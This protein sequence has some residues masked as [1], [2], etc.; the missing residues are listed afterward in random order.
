MGVLKSLDFLWYTY[1]VNVKFKNM[2]MFSHMI[3][4]IRVCLSI[5]DFISHWSV[6]RQLIINAVFFLTCTYQ[7]SHQFPLK[8]IFCL[9]HI[10]SAIYI[11][12]RVAHF[13]C[14]FG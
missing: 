7:N 5:K 2:S 6:S 11:K 4:I 8:N 13:E 3:S 12:E 14:Y 9:L 10:L 1:I